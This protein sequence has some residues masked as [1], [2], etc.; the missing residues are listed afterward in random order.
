MMIRA[1]IGSIL[2]GKRVGGGETCESCILMSRNLTLYY[3]YIKH[4]LSA[5]TLEYQSIRISSTDCVGVLL[6]VRWCCARLT[7]LTFSV[8][9]TAELMVIARNLFIV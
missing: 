9:R 3:R 5:V 2:G 6:P 7:L 4:G 8:T 1:C